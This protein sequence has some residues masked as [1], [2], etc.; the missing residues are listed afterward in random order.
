M[1]PCKEARGISS[2]PGGARALGSQVLAGS[3]AASLEEFYKQIVQTVTEGIVM[4]DALGRLTFV[5]RTAAAML[6]YK[7]ED[8]VGQPWT[9]IIGPE[10]QP[11]VEAA[12]RRRPSGE[13]SRYE[14]DLAC[15]D[16]TRLPVQVSG[17]PCF[18]SGKFVG[19]LA[20][21]SNVSELRQAEK[22]LRDGESRHDALLISVQRQSRERA[23][24]DQVRLVL[25]REMDLS[26]I[27]RDVVEATRTVLGYRLVSLYLLDGDILRL[28]HQVGYSSGVLWEIPLNRGICGR[29]AA[30]GQAVLVEDVS[31]DPDFLTT[32][33]HVSSEVCVPLFYQDH[34]F[35]V[36][37]VESLGDTRLSE[38]DLRLVSALAGDINIA[39][40]RAQLNE[41]ALRSEHER[42][43]MVERVYA[44]FERAQEVIWETDAQGDFTFLSPPWSLLTG[45]TVDES[46]GQPFLSF[47]H[48]DDRD[49][50]I[51]AIRT[52]A[53]AAGAAR[54]ELAICTKGGGVRWVDARAGS[55]Q[56]D[57]IWGTL[58]D[59]TERKRTENALAAAN[60]ELEKAVQNANDMAVAAEA[61]ALAKAEFLANMSH[62]IRTPMNAVIGMTGLLLATGLTP[63]QRDYVE[64]IR[65]SGEA[66]LGIIN[67]I[68]DFTKIDSGKLDLENQ[69][70]DL[71]ACVEEAVDLFAAKAS[72][73]GL[74]L[75]YAIEEGAPQ[76]IVGDVTRLRQILVNLI[77]NAVKFTNGGEVVIS[78]TAEMLEDGCY[79]L[80][81]AVRDTGIGIPAD[82][83]DHLFQSFSQLDA[84]TTRRFGGTGLGL[85]ISKRLSELMGGTMWVESDGLG[86]GSTFYFSIK[87]QA[88]TGQAA[89]M[90]A[91]GR[92]QLKGKRA[93]IVD[94]NLT[95]RRI[96]TA[97]CE[98]WGMIQH[99][100]ASGQEALAFIRHGGPIDVA[101]LDM[102]MPDMDGM[103]L[104]A[105][106]R[107]MSSS[108]PL[109]LLTPLGTQETR[110]GEQ[111]DLFAARLPKPV[112]GGPLCDVLS[113][114]LAGETVI[115]RP[116]A[117]ES[118]FDPELAKRHPL[119]ILVAEDNAVNQKLMLRVL[120]GMG[121]AAD[122]V[123]NGLEALDALRRQRYDLVFMDVQMPEMDG[124]EAARLIADEWPAGRRP[125]VVAMTAAAMSGDRELCLAAGMDD[126]VSKPVR[127]EELRSA[128][129]RWGEWVSTG[130][131][132]ASSAE[133]PAA[134]AHVNAA[135]CRELC[136]LQQ[137]G[138]PDVLTEMIDLYLSNTP[139]R[140]ETIRAAIATGDMEA[141]IFA[142]HSLKG[143]SGVFGASGML[144]L[145]QELD[146]L[147][148]SEQLGER[149]ARTF[150]KLEAEFACVAEDLA[151]MR[152][153]E[154]P[155]PIA[156]F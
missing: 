154:P 151:A 106:I 110:L 133:E 111:A 86:K 45:Y 62:E 145:C 17:T 26:A 51:A 38:P 44:V 13:S 29:V 8:L 14:I 35:G 82:R 102:Q 127:V 42:R 91:E 65:S 61:A 49:A 9:K 149:A 75:A 22:R 66:L 72:E 25:E 37:N 70:F 64:T 112:K 88:A 50:C 129:E 142:A 78:L 97:L 153:A 94:D 46:L 109:V 15:R 147:G 79:N 104:A 10:W 124:L 41:Q 122:A 90:P 81:F 67:D 56:G 119:R 20:V 148:R 139:P 107:V 48:S 117:P 89:D 74:E 11:V 105:E 141:L 3:E 135:L 99:A 136:E 28:Q 32:V 96:L 123:G 134:Q 132:S 43:A 52:M 16:G 6:G 30:T 101:V 103:R 69:P 4:E 114:V 7:A 125:V 87:A 77:G 84:S 85:A 12:D 156:G 152:C 126:Y 100:A 71:C 2:I 47:V 73:R 39:I 155:L 80:V 23:L 113:R 57:G 115:V 1:T 92:A 53:G 27:V 5:N 58:T 144:A 83:M 40:C 138:E 18:E 55:K 54:L 21:F 128:L 31:C 19:T 143:A 137:E 60:A 34:V 120:A 76:T 98:S 121:Y 118:L 130:A 116:A 108:M 95:S 33:D 93:L 68:L 140:L 150:E 24:L 131:S 146:E 59:I 36:I 63:D